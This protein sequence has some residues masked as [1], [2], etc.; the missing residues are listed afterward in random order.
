[1][2]DVFVCFEPS[3]IVIEQGSLSTVTKHFVMVVL[4]DFPDQQ[5]RNKLSKN[6]Y[7]NK[8]HSRNMMSQSCSNGEH[9]EQAL[10]E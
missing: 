10:K 3:F 9:G 1:M 8:Q 4:I 5:G 6:L 7:E 2:V